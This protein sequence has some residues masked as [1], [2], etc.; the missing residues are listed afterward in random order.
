MFLYSL[1]LIP[2]N[3]P[4]H[5]ISKQLVQ[6]EMSLFQSERKFL[7]LYEYHSLEWLNMLCCSLS[8]GWLN[9]Q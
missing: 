9:P 6:F 2:N 5:T 7:A 3:N 1:Y 4:L 8:E